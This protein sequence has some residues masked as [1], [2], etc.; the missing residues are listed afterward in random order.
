MSWSLDELNPIVVISGD[1]DVECL[2]ELE[3]L[4]PVIAYVIRSVPKI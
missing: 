4:N 3:K 2:T 1:S